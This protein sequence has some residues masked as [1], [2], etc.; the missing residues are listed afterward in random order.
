MSARVGRL[1]ATQRLGRGE[2]ALLA[3]QLSCTTRALRKW[4]ARARAG[5][6]SRPAHR[7]RAGAP[8]RRVLSLVVRLWRA[9]VRGHDGWRTLCAAA[10]RA[11][12]I[13]GA[14][15]LQGLVRRL[16]EKRAARARRRIL[17]Q[18]EHVAVLV[19][20]ALWSCDES[21]LGRD[22][23]G[24]VRGLLVRDPATSSALW[25]SVGA[26]ASGEAL[27]E[28]LCSTA[29]LRGG[30]PLVVALDNGGAN[31]SVPVQALL[32]AQQVVPLYNLPRTPQHNAFV[33]RAWGEI[34]CASGLGRTADGSS[35]RAIPPGTGVT[36]SGLGCE[37][38][39][40]LQNRLQAAQKAL[41]H[42]P[43]PRWGGITPAELDN[44]LPRA[45]DR[46]CRAR[47]YQSTCAALARIAELPL[48]ARARRRAERDAILASLE[49]H[50]LVTRT[51]GDGPSSR[52]SK[53]ND[54]A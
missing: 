31:R 39:A 6:S 23:A 27:A 38:R 2:Q 7:P 37:N 19:R 41:Q 16:K 28:A 54:S 20:D 34:K 10:R 15:L 3:R 5:G 12:L 14:R 46:T 43:R 42:T 24:E 30:W 22:A 18:R 35:P 13:L 40:A 50:G 36:V 17:C 51:R 33:E 26:P 45:D 25:A 49:W 4:R 29:R 52:P 11:G 8:G 47:Y 1:L 21:F 48:T 44:L 32:H 53:R 9:L